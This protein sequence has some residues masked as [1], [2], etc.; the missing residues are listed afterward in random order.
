MPGRLARLERIIRRIAMWPSEE[1]MDRWHREDTEANKVIT[2]GEWHGVIH[3]TMAFGE[4]VEDD[5]DDDDA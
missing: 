3:G 5:E 4:R 2:D 1:E